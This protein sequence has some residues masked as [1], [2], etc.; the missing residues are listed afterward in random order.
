MGSIMF[1]IRREPLDAPGQERISFDVNVSPV[2][3]QQYS[4]LRQILGP[5]TTD[6]IPPRP[7][8][9]VFAEVMLGGR[10]TRRD[11]YRLF[12]GIRS[13]DAPLEYNEGRLRFTGPLFSPLRGYLGTTPHP[14]FFRMFSAEETGNPEGPTGLARTMIGESY[15]ST[16]GDFTVLSPRPEIVQE[17]VPSLEY[18]PV[19][20]PAQIRLH[21]KDLA[22][23][24]METL[25]YR[26][27]YGRTIQ[28]SQ[29]NLGLLKVM[30]TQL[31][32]PREECLGTT[33]EL[34]DVR[35][36]CPLGGEYELVREAGLPPRWTSTALP[37]G[38]PARFRVEP[39]RDFR[40]P[41]L[42]WFRGMD[43]DFLLTRDAVVA[44]ADVDVQMRQV[45][46]LPP[47]TTETSP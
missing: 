32:V 3:E 30:A 47:P 1:G 15:Q 28:T 2:S 17:V 16:D 11:P 8:D 5:P 33:E 45:E 43:L 44:H 25:L 21:V 26:L 10:F 34:L 41:L 12:A 23:T 9:L 40:F 39:P 46:A 42:T 14:E 29:A 13:Y 36:V 31:K 6:R 27:V 37:D 22:G 4:L 19:N 18:E 24:P 20:R 38:I 7:S 35:L